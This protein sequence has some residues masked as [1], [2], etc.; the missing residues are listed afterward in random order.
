MYLLDTN[1]LIFLLF[2]SQARAKF[3]KEAEEIILTNDDLSVSDIS[4][5]EL[6]I[7][8]KIRFTVTTEMRLTE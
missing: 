8:D 5:W 2:N 4:L 6:A 1:A 3:S 7:K